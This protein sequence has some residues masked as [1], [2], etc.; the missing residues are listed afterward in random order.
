MLQSAIYQ[1]FMIEQ[2]LKNAENRGKNEAM[3]FRA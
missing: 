1:H 2:A 3:D